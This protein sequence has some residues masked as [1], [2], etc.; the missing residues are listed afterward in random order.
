LARRLPTA[1]DGDIGKDMLADYRANAV[2]CEWVSSIRN[3]TGVLRH[4]LVHVSGDVVTA[5]RLQLVGSRAKAIW[6]CRMFSDEC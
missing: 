5:E 1:S 6:F 4:S 2:E 3:F